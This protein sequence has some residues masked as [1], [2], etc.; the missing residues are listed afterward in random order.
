MNIKQLLLI[1]ILVV[2]GFSCRGPEGPPGPR[3]PEGPEGPG[4]LMWETNPFDFRLRHGEYQYFWPL[5]YQDV[6]FYDEDMFL[7]YALV[8]FNH[9]NEPEWEPLPMTVL[10]SEGVA[11]YTFAASLEEIRFIMTA[12]N[13]NFFTDPNLTDDWVMRIVMIPAW[14]GDDWRKG[15]DWNSYENVKETFNLPDLP[16]PKVE[17]RDR[18]LP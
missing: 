1:G 3:G 2:I 9:Y 18:K 12:T 15:P 7:A 4:A 5:P 17:P 10:G 6:D 11:N 13:D 14:W 8:G 16:A